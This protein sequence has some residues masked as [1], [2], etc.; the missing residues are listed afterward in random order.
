MITYVIIAEMLENVFTIMQI[1]VLL[2][3]LGVYIYYLLSFLKHYNS[4]GGD[5]ERGGGGV[6]LEVIDFKL[7]KSSTTD[8][9]K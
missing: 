2:Q 6:N 4:S 1:I 7:D 3:F 5:G 9:I 8:F